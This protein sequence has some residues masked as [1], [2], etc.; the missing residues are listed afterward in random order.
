MSITIIIIITTTVITINIITITIM[1]I[2][3]INI[4]A[5]ITITLLLASC[6][7]STCIYTPR[8]TGLQNICTKLTVGLVEYKVM[9][10]YQSLTS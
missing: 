1:T 7:A 5:I 9:G 4:I 10:I 6:T 8:K 3:I 2:T